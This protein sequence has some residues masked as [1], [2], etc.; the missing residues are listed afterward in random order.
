MVAKEISA[1]FHFQAT[2]LKANTF[3]LDYFKQQSIDLKARSNSL[4]QQRASAAVEVRAAEQPEIDLGYTHQMSD[5][6]H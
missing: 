4:Q 1:F 2:R 6:E 5:M 3:V